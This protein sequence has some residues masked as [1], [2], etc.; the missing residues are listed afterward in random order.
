MDHHHILRTIASV[1]VEIWE[2]VLSNL[3]PADFP[4]TA[5]PPGLSTL[6]LF[7]GKLSQCNIA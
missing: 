2:L 4:Q 7:E 6:T 5:V 3:G 1:P